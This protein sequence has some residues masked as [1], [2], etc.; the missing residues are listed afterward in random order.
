[1]RK[2]NREYAQVRIGNLVTIF[3]ML[4]PIVQAPAPVLKKTMI[5][6]STMTIERS[7]SVLWNVG[8]NTHCGP[9]E[10]LTKAGMPVKYTVQVTCKPH[11]DS[12]GFLFDQAM[13]DKWMRVVASQYTEL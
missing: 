11:L 8:G 5:K 6:L 4:F 10:M 9:K 1:M 2:T 13:V 3:A 12:R 7:G